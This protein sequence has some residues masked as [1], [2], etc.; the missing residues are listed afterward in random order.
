MSR[1]RSPAFM[2]HLGKK[3]S[4]RIVTAPVASST[5]NVQQIG[6]HG[7]VTVAVMSNGAPMRFASSAAASS[8]AR[9]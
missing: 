8:A 7:N 5:A 2:G 6:L 9:I 4:S 1:T 3:T